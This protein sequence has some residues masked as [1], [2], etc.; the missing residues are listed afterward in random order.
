MIIITAI[1]SMSVNPPLRSVRLARAV[2]RMTRPA[3][4]AVAAEQ[5]DPMGRRMAEP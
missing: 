4:L 3:H 2:S 5:R 1:I